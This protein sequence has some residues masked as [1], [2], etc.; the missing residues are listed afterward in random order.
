MRLICVCSA[1]HAE[2]H[3]SLLA[4]SARI[5]QLACQDIC[6]THTGAHS[7][8]YV[9]TRMRYEYKRALL[10]RYPVISVSQAPAFCSK[11]LSK[12]D[13]RWPARAR[14]ATS[15]AARK[16]QHSSVCADRP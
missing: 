4:R 1:D 16:A 8:G 13:Q 15:A 10:V 6:L 5:C 3:A 9:R 11:H 14:G 12:R 7:K 2:W